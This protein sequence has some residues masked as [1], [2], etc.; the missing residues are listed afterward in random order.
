[1][2]YEQNKTEK[3]WKIIGKSV[4]GHLKYAFIIH[5]EILS[6]GIYSKEIDWNIEKRDYVFRWYNYF[7]EKLE[8]ISVS[9]IRNNIYIKNAEIVKNFIAHPKWTMI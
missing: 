7:W 6:A 5:P 2:A 8:I 3:E 9:K 1:M 4:S